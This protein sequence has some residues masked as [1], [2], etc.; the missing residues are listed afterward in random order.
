MSVMKFIFGALLLGQFLVGPAAAADAVMAKDLAIKQMTMAGVDRIKIDRRLNGNTR[1]RGYSE[2][3]LHVVIID[4]KSG[5]F[6][7]DAVIDLPLHSST[8]SGLH[9]SQQG[10]DFADIEG[11]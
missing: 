6:V 7:T 9:W 3:E 1:V 4:K 5:R 8:Q 10:P 11:R 2:T